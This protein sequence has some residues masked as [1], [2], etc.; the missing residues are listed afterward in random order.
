MLAS[1]VN[2]EDDNE[3]SSFDTSA[4]SILVSS[5]QEPSS[6]PNLTD[7]SSVICTMPS[8]IDPTIATAAT[9]AKS[10][11][12]TI[13]EEHEEATSEVGQQPDFERGKQAALKGK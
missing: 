3:D 9:V 11:L 1:I 7:P 6:T 5:F 2:V 13:L 4:F 12:N 8:L 10:V